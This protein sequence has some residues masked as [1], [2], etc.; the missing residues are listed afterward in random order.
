MNQNEYKKIIS[1][2][3]QREV[4]A[5]TFYHN[6]SAKAKDKSIKSIFKKLAEEELEHRHTLEG[7]LIK[8]SEKCIFRSPRIIKLSMHFPRRL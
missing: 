5:Y 2:A 1:L 4:E 7:F 8:T 3:I 6:V